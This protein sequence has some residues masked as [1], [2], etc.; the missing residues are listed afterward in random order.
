MA[1]QDMNALGRLSKVVRSQP[2]YLHQ[3]SIKSR[4]LDPFLST[5]FDVWLWGLI[6]FVQ[7][8]KMVKRKT[9]PEIVMQKKTI[10]PFPPPPSGYGRGRAGEASRNIWPALIWAAVHTVMH[11]LH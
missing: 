3:V 7:C 1:L 8:T 6:T 11:A 5:A 2:D 4:N 9:I 10:G